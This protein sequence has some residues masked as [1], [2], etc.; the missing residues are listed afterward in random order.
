MDK[1]KISAI[2]M[3]SLMICG[4][5]ASCSNKKSSEKAVEKIPVTDE[6][7][8]TEIEPSF[9]AQPGDAY[10]AINEKNAYVKY[11]GKNDD[12][13]QSMLSYNAGVATITGNG[14]YTVSV[15]ADTNGFRRDTT[16]DVNNYSVVPSGLLFAALI[17]EDGKTL[18]P[19]AVLTI[20]SIIVDGKELALKAK[21]YT[22]SDDGIELRS[23]IYNEW[24]TK[25]PKDAVSA[26]GSIPEESASDYSACLVDTADFE[27]WTT[28]EVNFTV[29]GLE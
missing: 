4:T 26:E 8:E 24:R 12:P 6:S 20:D 15:T 28:V 23:N 7:E 21:N 5:F 29:S 25:L 2:F 13:S 1:K 3:L 16:G 17:I 11:F 19:D 9:A 14:N 10:L 22:S 18:F 27:T